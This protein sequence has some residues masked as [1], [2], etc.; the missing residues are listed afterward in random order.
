MYGEKNV[1]WDSQSHEKS[2]DLKV[3]INN[4]KLRISAKGGKIS[5]QLLTISS[6]RLT[7]FNTLEE[8]LGFIK[9]Q[10]KNFNFYLIC[11]REISKNKKDRNYLIIKTPS[12]KFAPAWMLDKNNWNKTNSGYELKNGLGFRAI[13]VSKMSDQLWYSI[14]LSYFS[15]KEKIVSISIPVTKLGAGLISYLKR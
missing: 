3:K 12:N 9:D 2:V 4:S 8:K 7:T 1:E 10:H 6:Y 11:A 5:N 13:I 14:P 15:K